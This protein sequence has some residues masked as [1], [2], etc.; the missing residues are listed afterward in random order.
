MEAGIAHL[1]PGDFTE[2]VLASDFDILGPLVTTPQGPMVAKS[3]MVSAKKMMVFTSRVPGYPDDAP[4]GVAWLVYGIR[5]P[6]QAPG[7]WLQLFA[8]TQN[9][10]TWRAKPAIIDYA[11]AFELFVETV[12]TTT[13]TAKYGDVLAKYILDRS[14]WIEER[15]K[16]PLEL[17]I[18]HRLSE[19][20]RDSN[21]VYHDWR[22]KVKDVR[23]DLAH[24]TKRDVT[25]EQAEEAH[26]AT[27]AAMRWIAQY[28]P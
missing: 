22:A 19:G 6:D 8:A 27:I 7:W 21:R 10:T 23:D 11:G 18:G 15:V 20:A 24:G 4:V 13:L 14:K 12:L 2:I 9:A 3:E 16:I 25:P 1:R 26:Q 28:L 17:A 5:G